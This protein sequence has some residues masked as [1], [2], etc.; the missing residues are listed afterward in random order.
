[1]DLSRAVEGLG[2]RQVII[3]AKDGE[4]FKR[5]T[6]PFLVNWDRYAIACRSMIERLESFFD[7]YPKEAIALVSF[8]ADDFGPCLEKNCINSRFCCLPEGIR[9]ISLHPATEMVA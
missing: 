9:V 3:L 2:E 6:E 4:R 5:L 7:Q 8:S 1:M